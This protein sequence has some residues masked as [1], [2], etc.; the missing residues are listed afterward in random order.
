MA[1]TER[2]A[3]R[4]ADDVCPACEQPVESVVARR[5][6]LGI[7]VPRWVPGPCHNPG[8]P[9]YEGEPPTTTGSSGRHV[10]A[11]RRPEPRPFHGGSH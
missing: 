5:K 3:G 8:C 6:T 9:R 11:P 4:Q 7:F 2:P 10:R 1:R